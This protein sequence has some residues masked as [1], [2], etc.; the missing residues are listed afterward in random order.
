MGGGFSASGVLSP[1]CSRIRP[2]AAASVTNPATLIRF[3]QRVQTS[4]ST[5]YTLA[6]SRALV[7]RQRWRGFSSCGASISGSCDSPV[8]LARFEY[9]P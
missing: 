8:P 7:D 1:R 4:G 3:L 5:W 6:S 9:S 2:I